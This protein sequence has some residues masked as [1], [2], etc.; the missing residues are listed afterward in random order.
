MAD[1]DRFLK[2]VTN[3]NTIQNNYNIPAIYKND[4]SGI[5]WC[6]FITFEV[7]KKML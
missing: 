1:Y 2:T 4:P 3:K 6:K 5:V 7:K